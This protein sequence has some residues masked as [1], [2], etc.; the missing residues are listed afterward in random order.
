MIIYHDVEETTA[1]A[2]TDVKVEE[3]LKCELWMSDSA[4]SLKSCLEH[5][6]PGYKKKHFT[7]SFQS[8]QGEEM[9]KIVQT[10]LQCIHHNFLV[11]CISRP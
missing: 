5:E 8:N 4:N 10:Y 9:I 11:H 3:A 6:R 7:I 1:V 2:V